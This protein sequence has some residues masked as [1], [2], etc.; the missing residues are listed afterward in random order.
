MM[1]SAPLIDFAAS[2]LP[3]AEALPELLAALGGKAA[4]C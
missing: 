3:A 2:G 1:T 4:L